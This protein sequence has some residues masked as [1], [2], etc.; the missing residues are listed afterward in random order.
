MM[1]F[2][3]Y[4]EQ[5]MKGLEELAAGSCQVRL[6]EKLKNNGVKQ[7]GVTVLWEGENVSP[8]I[9]LDPFYQE[10]KYGNGTISD[11]VESIYET[12]EKHSGKTMESL[13]VSDIKVWDKMKDRIHAKLINA[14]LNQELLENVP[15][16]LVLDLAEVYY[17]KVGVLGA[18]EDGTSFGSILVTN[19]QAELWDV[20]EEMLHTQAGVC[21]ES[22]QV[23]F[24]NMMEIIRQIR[25]DQHLEMEDMEDTGMYVLTNPEK[26]YGAVELLN[27]KV[28]SDI[29]EDL[30]DDLLLLPSSIHELIILRA[31]DRE[32]RELADMVQEVN[33]TNL[34]P[35]EILS[36]HVYCFDRS[37]RKLSIAA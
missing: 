16:R 6:Q 33:D 17:V 32:C 18:M 3:E 9:Y 19:A 20:D 1:N 14:D 37:T 2:E 11:A 26:L 31:E 15:H 25:L 5:V 21:M 30:Q 13:N 29:A 4:T 7:T 10:Y 8:I 36:Y 23:E 34:S 27:E 35:D 12:L 28:L 22:E 24:V